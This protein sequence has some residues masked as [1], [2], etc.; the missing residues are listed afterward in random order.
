MTNSP[1]IAFL[2]PH[3]TDFPIPDDWQRY[4]T[5]AQ[6]TQAN[7]DVIVIDMPQ[8]GL[9]RA[10]VELRKSIYPL[11]LIFSARPA[12]G[13][14]FEQLGDGMLPE[15][16]DAVLPLYRLWQQRLHSFNRGQPSTTTEERVLAWLWSRPRSALV[17]V[18]AP[19]QA[20]PYYYPLVDVLTE[21]NTINAFSWLQLMQQQGLFAEGELLDR[22]RQCRECSST[23]LNYIDV[24]P[25]CQTIDI[26]RQ[27]SL[28]CFTCGHVAPQESFLKN[29]TLECPNCL[30]RLRHIGSDYD[31][32]LENLRC[33]SC[34][35]FFEEPLVEAHCLDCQHINA[36]EDLKV[37]EIRRYSLTE[38]GRLK[39]RQGLTSSLRD[40]HFD[41]LN[42][43]NNGAFRTLLN[44]QIQ[45]THRYKSHA[46]SL[47]AIKFENLEAAMEQ[48]GEAGGIAAIDTL[49]SRIREAIRETDRCTRSKENLLWLLLPN[50]DIEGR[51][52]LRNRILELA[53]LLPI[54]EH[55]GFRVVVDGYTLPMELLPQEDAE[56]VM[57]R[58][59][60]KL[61]A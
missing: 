42:L 10:I 61:G 5:V 29:G 19:R 37:R 33:R 22:L 14:L 3:T 60:G 55:S 41:Q 52:A 34:N 44:W 50:T 54:A 57:A 49:V 59:A 6:L 38:L 43:I 35:A 2:A 1:N 56:L 11:N 48:V 8:E 45:L 12:N 16:T 20:I 17:P 18:R 21:D 13:P 24:C 23:R 15:A 39:C 51:E 32:P 53:Q 7:C 58:L 28:H 30:T 9:E 27:P 26:A 46:T 40:D 47:M 4:E 25:D 31:R 36:P